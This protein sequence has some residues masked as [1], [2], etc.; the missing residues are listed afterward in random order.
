MGT[1][2]SKQKRIAGRSWGKRR[3]SL[4]AAPCLKKSTLYAVPSRAAARIDIY[5]MH[6]EVA[7][8]MHSGCLWHV[9]R[10]ERPALCAKLPSQELE[11]P[12]SLSASSSASS[13][14]PSPSSSPNGP[15]LST[16]GDACGDVRDVYAEKRNEC[17]NNKG[18][19]PTVCVDYVGGC[20]LARPRAS[21]DPGQESCDAACF[22]KSASHTI[23]CLGIYPA[24]TRD[25]CQRLRHE[26]TVMC[27]VCCV[28][29]AEGSLTMH[30]D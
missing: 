21:V 25:P 12:A 10:P 27:C 7:F 5:P 30:V 19:F 29:T 3:F 4:S 8:I 22:A 2:C 26:E 14:S 20:E 24:R 6:A 13:S 9:F 11:E 17:N 18:K 16:C 28:V 1:R 23:D 15:R